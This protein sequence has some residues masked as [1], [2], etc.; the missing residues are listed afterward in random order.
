MRAVRYAAWRIGEPDVK[1]KFCQRK[2]QALISC[3]S[4]EQ[5]T[6]HRHEDVW[7]KQDRRIRFL[8]WQDTSHCQDVVVVGHE[9]MLLTV[10]TQVLGFFLELVV[11]SGGSCDDC[12]HYYC[13]HFY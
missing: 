10:K 13:F 3:L 11:T 9:G 12:R 7:Q 1:A 8:L 2:G 4:V 5:P 6:V